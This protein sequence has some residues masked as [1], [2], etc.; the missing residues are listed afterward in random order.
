MGRFIEGQNRQ[1]AAFLPDCLDD[2]VG[3]DNPVRMVDAFVDS[4][5]LLGLGFARANPASTGRPAYHPA[6]LL[7]LYIYGYLNQV[8]SSRRLEREASRNTELMWLTHKLAPDFKTIADFRR[9]NA[10]AIK[11]AGRQFIDICRDLGLAAGGVVAVD[12]SKFWGVN[13]HNNNYTRAKLA[14]RVDQVGA[15][16]EHYL[17]ELD[18]ADRAEAGTEAPRVARLVEKIAMLRERMAELNAIGERLEASPDGQISLTDPDARAMSA[19]AGRSV[20]GYNVQAA[21]DAEHHLVVAHEVIN[22]VSDRNQLAGMA[23]QAKAAMGADA[24]TVV[25]DR[26]Y[27]DG[28]EMLACVEAGVTPL[29]PKPVNSPAKAKGQWGKHDFAYESETDTYRCPVGQQLTRRFASIE[30]GH[31]IHIYFTTACSTCAVKARCT[32]G[33]ERRIRR[34]ER[35]GE[36]EAL[37]KRLD[38]TPNA[39]ALRRRTVEHVFGTLKRWMGATH[40]QT[41]GMTGVGAEMSLT[42]LAYNMTRTLALVGPRAAVTAMRR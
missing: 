14:R 39:M 7:K 15:R 5:D 28:D 31:T 23:I 18:V 16:I 13:A 12:G 1:Q 40:F 21:V 25:A 41:K 19:A 6:T 35:E 8:R 17:T 38:A 2:Y 34:W 26:G 10:E 29:V 9:D 32:T 3:L 24:L 22:K 37:Q 4:L 20:V 33:K 27:Y 42:V 36:I 30:Q 11:A